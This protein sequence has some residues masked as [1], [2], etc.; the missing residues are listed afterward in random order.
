MIDIDIL[1]YNKRCA[2]FLGWKETTLEFKMKWLGVK[3]DGLNK[4]RSSYIPILEKDGDVF[5]ED[6]MLF[7]LDWNL[8]MDMLDAIE[9][10]GYATKID[11]EYAISNYGCDRCEI[12]TKENTLYK[13]EDEIKKPIA[14]E[15]TESK[16]EAVVKTIDQFLIW[17]EKQ[18]N[19]MKKLEPMHIG[20]GVYFIDDG[21]Y[22]DISEPTN[23][24]VICSLNVSYLDRAID[25]LQAVKERLNK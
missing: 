24:N 12:D 4:L 2:L 22:I 6:T 20:D 16:K 15:L 7:H 18:N 25:Y 13:D 8:I 23:T 9:E 19:I 11:H 5:F 14:F 1:E 10:L 3:L 21:E 17:N